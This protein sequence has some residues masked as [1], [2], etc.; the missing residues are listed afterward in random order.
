MKTEIN[1]EYTIGYRSLI[2]SRMFYFDFVPFVGM[3]LT[4][5][6]GRL[7]L[8]LENGDMIFFITTI[9]I[10]SKFI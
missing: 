4:E 6:S 2:F 5:D 1:V 9:V 3:V 10:V 8:R 7:D